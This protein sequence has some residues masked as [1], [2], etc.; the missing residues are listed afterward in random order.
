LTMICRMISGA[1]RTPQCARSFSSQVCRLRD[2]QIIKTVADLRSWR[3]SQILNNKSVGL[4]PTMGALH[5]GH[6]GLVSKSLQQDDS[7]IV[8]VFVNPSQFAPHEDLDKYPRTLD[9]DME[10]LKSLKDSPETPIVVF[11]PTVNEMY[12]T[13]I[14]LHVDKQVGAFVEVKGLSEQLEG[15]IRPQFF[16][17]VATIVTKLLNIV[18]PERAY[19]GQKDV[20][21]SIVVKRLVKDLILPTEVVVGKTAREPNGLAMSSRNEYLTPESRNNAKILFEALSAGEKMYA[22]NKTTRSDILGAVHDVLS[23]SGFAIEVEYVALSDKETLQ[24]LDNV[25][26]GIGGIISAAIRVPNKV[27]SMT[28]IIDNIILD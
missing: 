5:E 28:R 18:T 1:A 2:I 7:T 14:T 10:A 22:A 17:G 24:E 9:T 21:Q 19:F 12:P 16:R 20:Q 13:G 26:K 3:K 23:A 11:L 4:V 15:S 27:G 8:S 6:L 25:E